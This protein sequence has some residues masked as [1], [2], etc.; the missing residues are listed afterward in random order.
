MTIRIPSS[1]TTGFAV[2][3]HDRQV[4]HTHF[5]RYS[6]S[7]HLLQ[8]PEFLVD[9][10][11]SEGEHVF[12]DHSESRFTRRA[13]SRILVAQFLNSNS[14]VLKRFEFG[15]REVVLTGH[16]VSGLEPLD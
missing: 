12:L 16:Y 7:G 9:A 15:P 11:R 4:G 2:F 13:E 3:L 5:V 6:F 14:G 8:L 1:V 10:D